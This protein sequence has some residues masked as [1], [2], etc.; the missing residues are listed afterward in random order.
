MDRDENFYFRSIPW[1]RD[2][3]GLRSRRTTRPRCESLCNYG[4]VR[5]ATQ[6]MKIQRQT[7][8]S[9]FL[10]SFQW[11]TMLIFFFFLSQILQ[12]DDYYG[13]EKI[14]LSKESRA[15]RI[16]DLGNSSR[17]PEQS[18]DNRARKRDSDIWIVSYIK[19]KL[20]NNC[21]SHRC[22]TENQYF[23]ITGIGNISLQGLM[24]LNAPLLPKLLIKR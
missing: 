17:F 7:S 24:L 11:R 16:Q 8:L 23:Y 5:N 19:T 13:R 6:K 15:F 20:R 12:G 3:R 18:N 10:P 4:D 1:T 2:G 14:G 22:M 9:S 21:Y